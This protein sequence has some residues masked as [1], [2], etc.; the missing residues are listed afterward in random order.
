MYEQYIQSNHTIQESTKRRTRRAF[1][2]FLVMTGNP[3]ADQVSRADVVAYQA[4]LMKGGKSTTTVNSYAAQV[5]AVFGW[6][7]SLGVIEKNPFTGVRKLR[8]QRRQ[9]DFYE[10]PQLERMLA[11]VDELKWRDPT[12]PMRMRGIILMAYYLGLRIGEILNLRWL[13][14]DL[15]NATVKVQYRSARDGEW[16]EWGDK[17][18]EDRHIPM[19]QEVLEHYYRLKVACPW[20]YPH[21]PVQRCR[22]L[23]GEAKSLP[24]RTRKAPMNNLYQRLNRIKRMAG[25]PAGE[26]FHKMRRTAATELSERLQPT[27]LQKLMGHKSF[28]TTQRYIGVRKSRY[29]DATREAMN[30]RCHS[31]D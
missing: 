10:S 2:P 21:L 20:M 22:A 31:K 29:L 28:A 11:A 17:G 7:V 4:L 30:A 9:V 16:W 27:D 19:P 23:Q 18:F 26:A 6:F 14:I 13:D 24:E 1:M 15:E 25:I 3:E 12:Q 5:S 8:E